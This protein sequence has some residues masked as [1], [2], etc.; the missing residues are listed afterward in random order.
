MARCSVSR[1]PTRRSATWRFVNAAG[2]AQNFSGASLPSACA[3]HGTVQDFEGFALSFDAQYVS[4]DAGCASTAG[5][6]DQLFIISTATG[7]AE[8][9]NTSTYLAANS[10]LP[11]DTL[12]CDDLSNPGAAHSY[13]VTA[14]GTVTPLGSGE[15]TWTTTNVEW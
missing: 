14:A 6:F 8:S 15:A 12:L 13:L 2:V 11:D 7:T 1:I 9:V 3:G 4:V 10:W 5:R